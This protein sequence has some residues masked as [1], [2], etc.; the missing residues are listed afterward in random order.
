MLAWF[1]IGAAVYL[2]GYI[3]LLPGVFGVLGILWVVLGILALAR[4]S[5]LAIVIDEAGILQVADEPVQ[6]VGPTAQ[7]LSRPHLQQPTFRPR[8]EVSGGVTMHSH[9]RADKLACT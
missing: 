4:R 6:P 3:G 2:G 1:G 9:L 5:Q 8:P 7:I